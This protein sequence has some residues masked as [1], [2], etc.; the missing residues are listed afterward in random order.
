MLADTD[1]RK[2][3]DECDA[4]TESKKGKGKKPKLSKDAKDRLEDLKLQSDVVRAREKWV[5]RIKSLNL[6][7]TQS[8]KAAGDFA[9]LQ[10]CLG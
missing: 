5:G 6:E 4:L 7:V 8:I 1:Q 9:F 2:S 10:Q 3:D